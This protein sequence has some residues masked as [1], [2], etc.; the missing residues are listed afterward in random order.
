MDALCIDQSNTTEKSHQVRMM[1][2]IFARSSTVLAC[3]GPHNYASTTLFDM[4]EKNRSLLK[5]IHRLT[6]SSAV[7]NKGNWVMLNPILESSW[8]HLR[9]FFAINTRQRQALALAFI[10]FM[11][12]SY[13][14]R[15]W[16]LQELHL[17]RKILLCCGMDIGSFDLLL[18]VSMLV[19]FW[20]DEFYY[21]HSLP[22]SIAFLPSVFFKQAWL[23]RRTRSCFDL[24]IFFHGIQ[25]QRGCLTQ[26]GQQTDGLTDRFNRFDY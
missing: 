11:K 24:R 7:R 2:E 21:K 6:I 19:E 20:T 17:A 16:I 4:M 22:V 14:S 23:L 15:V 18:A 8:V 26:C 3:V 1:G 12:R 10:A 5:S 9:C 13:F 25:P